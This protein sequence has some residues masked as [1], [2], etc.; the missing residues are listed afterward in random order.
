MKNLPMILI[1]I[2]VALL[3]YWGYEYSQNNESASLA[4]VELSVSRSTS[5]IPLIL[6]G[7]ALLGGIGMF[8]R[9]R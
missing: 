2:G 1:V 3:G 7:L 5:P 6:G 9:K 8:A 4:G